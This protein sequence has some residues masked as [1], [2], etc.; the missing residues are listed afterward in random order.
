MFKVSEIQV[1]DVQDY[2]QGV[3]VLVI[4]V[5]VVHVA[6]IDIQDVWNYQSLDVQ[7][8]QNY[9]TVPKDQSDKIF[10][11]WDLSENNYITNLTMHV[12]VFVTLLNCFSY[13]SPTNLMN[14]F[15]RY[16]K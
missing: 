9:Q 11:D 12:V 3:G 5:Q 10:L 2:V 1:V 8:I 6:V 7:D 15:Q 4:D 16:I 14:K 13:W